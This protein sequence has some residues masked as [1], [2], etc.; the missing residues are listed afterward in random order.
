MQ[1][2]MKTQKRDDKKARKTLSPKCK[3]KGWK[4]QKQEDKKVS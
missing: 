4:T 1:K 2:R 3:Q